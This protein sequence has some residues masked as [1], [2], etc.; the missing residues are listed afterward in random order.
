LFYTN[1][2]FQNKLYSQRVRFPG[3]WDFSFIHS[4]H[5]RGTAT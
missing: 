3:G 5:T 2:K 4:V 1:N